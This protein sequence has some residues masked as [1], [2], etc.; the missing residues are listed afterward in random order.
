MLEIRK[1]LME[2]AL[3]NQEYYM[4][5]ILYTE[6]E[7]GIPNSFLYALPDKKTFG[8]A[9]EFLETEKCKQSQDKYLN[10]LFISF[11]RSK[12]MKLSEWDNQYGYT[13][14]K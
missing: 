8:S 9:Q 7:T 14:S 12:Y 13:L 6:F 2:W 10:Q 4:A 5:Y 11:R 1:I 3:K